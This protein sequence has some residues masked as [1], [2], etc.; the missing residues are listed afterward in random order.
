MTSCDFRRIIAISDKI[1]VGRSETLKKWNVLWEQ[2]GR[3]QGVDQG[4]WSP[5]PKI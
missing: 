3:I 1:D 2:Q 5:P 4:D